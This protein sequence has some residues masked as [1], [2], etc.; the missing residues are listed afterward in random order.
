MRLFFYGF[1][2]IAF[3][4][5]AQ[6]KDQCNIMDSKQQLSQLIWLTEDYPP[7]NYL[8][9][10]GR[11]IGSSTDTLEA[12]FNYLKLDIDINSIKVMP[13]A[14]LY[15]QMETSAE[16]AAFSM[17]RTEERQQKFQMVAMPFKESVSILVLKSRLK[18][19]KAKPME[20]LKVGVVREDIGHQLLKASGLKVTQIVSTSASNILKQLMAGRIDAIAYTDSVIYFQMAK[21]ISSKDTLVPFLTLDESNRTHFAFNNQTDPCIVDLFAKTLNELH[22]RGDILSIYDKYY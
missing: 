15:Y 5:F 4:V 6:A 19:L 7:Y 16:H 17:L 2:L 18:S 21:H 22:Q 14:R 10:K 9:E 20:L 12:V 13:W 3:N 1:L 8:D 11:L